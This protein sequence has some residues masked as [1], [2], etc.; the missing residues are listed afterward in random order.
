MNEWDEIKDE[1]ELLLKLFETEHLNVPERGNL[2]NGKVRHSVARKLIKNHLKNHGWFPGEKQ[3][4]IGD[5]GGEYY[6]LELKADGRAIL[7]H[8]FEYSYLKF[9]HKTIQSNSIDELI[10]SYLIEKEEEGLDGLEI[11]WQS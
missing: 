7:H 3:K 11:D 5:A 4:P 9:R 6:Q 8:N 1:K 2:P 10:K